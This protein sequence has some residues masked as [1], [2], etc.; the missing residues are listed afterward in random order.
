PALTAQRF[1][2]DPYGPPGSRM[3]RTGDLARMDTDGDLIYLGRTDHQVKIRGHRIE[4]AEIERALAEHPQVRQAVVLA[5]HRPTGGPERAGHPGQ[6]DDQRLVAYVVPEGREAG[7]EETATDEQVAEWRQVYDQAYAASAEVEW[8]EDFGIW[9]ST[10]TGEPI[11]LAEMRAWRDAAVDRVRGLAPRRVLELGVGTGLLLAHLAGEAEEYWGTDFSP[12]VID[13]LRRQVADAGLADRVRL[14]C[15]AADVTDGLPRGHFDAVVLNSVVQYFPHARY[16]AQVLDAAWEAL[17]PGGAIVV[18]DVRRAGT[19]R[20]LQGAV[21]RARQPQAPPSVLRAAVEQAVLLE[22]ELVVEPE[23]F[24]RWAAERGVGEVD[25]RLKSGRAHNELTR[26]RYEVVLRKAPPA[27]TWEAPVELVWGR[28]FAPA[29]DTAAGTTV[30]ARLAGPLR[31]HGDGPLRLSGIPN[32]RLA[33]ETA[34]AVELG[35]LAG[36]PAAAV[37]PEELREWAAGQGRTAVL[38]W[39]SYGVDRFDALL[40][41]AGSEPGRFVPW[42]PASVRTGGHVPERA[43][44]SAPARTGTRTGTPDGLSPLVN[45]PAAARRVAALPAALREHL[46]E[47]LPEYMLPSAVVPLGE[48]PLT[49]NGK[50]DRRA[51]PAPD[52]AATSGTGRA[53]ATPREK[54]LC[55]LFAEVLGVDRVGADDGFFALGGHSLLATRLVSRIRTVLGAE[56]PLRLVFQAPTPAALAA[57]LTAAA[58]GRP[59]LEPAERPETV[60]LSF[61]QRRMWFSYQLEG[62]SATYNWPLAL[63]LSGRLDAPA[64]RRALADVVARHESLRTVF[65][66]R[67]GQPCQRVLPPGAAPVPWEDRRLSEAELPEAMRRAARHTFDLSA[68]P[69]LRVWLFVT[70]P[71]EHVLLVLLHHIAGDGWSLEP[72]ARDLVTAYAARCA[73]GAPDWP[74]LPVQYVDYTL[75]QRRLL[76]DRDDPGS[77]YSRQLAYWREQLAGAPE[78]LRLPA[79]RPRP[80]VTSHAGDLAGFHLAAGLVGRLARLASAA[81]ATMAMVLQAGLAA[82][83]T[84]LGAGEDIPVGSP[85][86]G[87]TDEALHELVGFFVNTWVLRADTSGDPSFTE[88]LRRVRETSLAAYEHQDLPFDLLVE[89]LNPARSTA[90][91]SLFQVALALQ[92]NARPDFGLPGLRVRPESAPTGTA[93]FDL[94]LSLTERYD[95]EGRPA[96]IEGVAEYATDLFDRAGVEALLDRWRRLLE[97]VAADPG[98]PVGRAD[99]LTAEERDRLLRWAGAGREPV[100]AGVPELFARRVAETPG[101]PALVQG[102]RHWSYAGLDAWA[103]RFAHR[104][105]ALGA[106]PERRVALRMRRS[107]ALVAAVLGVLKAGAAYVPVDPDHPAERVAWLLEDSA[108]VAVVDDTWAE[109]DAAEL[110]G[111]PSTDPGVRVTGDHAA[112]LLYTSGSTGRPKGVI[113]THRNVTDLATD[114]CFGGDAHRGTLL[115]SPHTF[116]AS[117]YE[118]W[119]PLLAGGTVVVAPPG[120]L[121]PASLARAVTEDGVTA[122]W[123]TAGLFAVIADEHPEC[124]AGA[125][126]VWAGGDVLPPDAVRRVLRANPGLTVVNGYGPTETTTFATCHA[127]RTPGDLGPES[128]PIGT[129]LHGGRAFVLDRWLAPVPPGVAGELYVAGEGLARGYAGRPALTAERFVP[130]PYGPPGTRMYRTGDLVRWDTEG[131]LVFLGRADE[132][133]KL[134]GFRVEPG[135][136]EAVLREQP[137]VA[138]AVVVAREDRLRDRSLIA[139]VVPDGRAASAAEAAEQVGEWREIYDEMYGTGPGGDGGTGADQAGPSAGTGDGASGGPGGDP[140]ARTGSG[141]E[142]GPGAGAAGGPGGEP[143]SGTGAGRGSGTGGAGRL[144]EDFTGWNSSYTGRPIPVAEMRAWRDAA[145]ARVSEGRPRRVL[146][147]GVGSGLLLGPLAPATEAYWGTDFSAPVIDRLRRQVAADPELRDRVTLRCQAAEDTEGLPRAFFDTVVLN[148]VVQYFP[149]AD[150]LR[151]V[152]DRAM[153]LLVPGGRIVVGDVRNL[154]TLRA[155][156]T[157]VHR[158]QRPGDP[159]AAVHAAVE[160]AVLGEKEL[161]LDS[162]FFTAWAAERPE[163]GAVDIRLKCGAPHNELTRHR[164]E[165][166]LRKHPVEPVPLGRAPELAWDREFGGTGGRSGALLDAL[167]GAVAAAGGPL[168]VTGI[169]NARLTGEAAEARP[170]AVDPEELR[171]RCAERGLT[172]LCTWSPEAPDRFEAV[173]TATGRAAVPTTRPATGPEGVPAVGPATGPEGIPGAVP[174]TRPA[175]GPEGVPTAGPA[176]GPEGAGGVCWDGVYRADPARTR[177]SNAPAVSRSVARLPS[178]L[179]ER[180]AERLPEFMVPAAVV[181]LDRL[182]LTV[183][184]KLDRA[185]LP[186]PGRAGTAAHRPPRTEPERVLAAL[187][188]EVLGVDRVGLD[189]DF[190]DLG[191]HSL[192]VIRLIWRIRERLGAEI[193]IRV[194]FQSPTVAG[195]VPHLTPDEGREVMPSDPY[196]VLLPIRTEGE[197]LPLWW[198]HPGGGLC[199][200]YL[201]FAPHL[202][203]G[204]PVYGVQ[205]RGFHRG[206]ARPESIEEMVD[207]YL[208]QVRAV[209]PEGPYHLLGWS[210]GGTVAH[211]MAAE[212]QSRG[213]EVALLALLDCV[214]ASHFTRFDAPDEAQVREFLGHYMGHLDGMEEYPFLVETAASILVEHTVLMQKFGQPV[215]RGDAHFFNALLDPDGRGERRLETPFHAL[216]RPHVAGAVRTYDIACT[217]QEM[218]WPENAAEIGAI[219]NRLA[220]PGPGL[221]PGPHPGPGSGLASAYAHE[222]ENTPENKP[223]STRGHNGRNA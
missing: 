177:L 87:R 176:A 170:D 143:A 137:G 183:N 157:A 133:L 188:A 60:P 204:R 31:A 208:A 106:G 147:L 119:V 54:A 7:P 126:E 169:P 206:S 223:A 117:T 50:L 164:Y 71:E 221:G 175:T 88:L 125:R 159:A 210:F 70:G 34:L 179:R 97:Q 35:F 67:D 74:P 190:F 20:L 129:P 76:G 52:T 203:P 212:L 48:V 32:A 156:H 110:R 39:S 138:R 10:Y 103:N 14:R 153:E 91:H 15:Q 142:S 84:R 12:S 58:D 6:A 191:G 131:R 4:P 24:A 189:D 40:L 9:K 196:A 174:T 161:V 56:L 78:V 8:G 146:E 168:R 166:V 16:L 186:E 148:S 181:V 98:A 127:V 209:Q 80:P 51:L 45:D 134:R 222:P 38:S 112:Y 64:L 105:I 216:W 28:D 100:R 135:E 144:G 173:V 163:A 193:P 154:G 94:F 36:D 49:P 128:V 141:A 62:P 92:N 178:L 201:G 160:R 218:Y 130:C 151:R 207:D 83:L 124:L 68:E 11:P 73:G 107:P 215:F 136:I 72:F 1:T 185:A 23:W 43:G 22:K 113:T 123:L 5:R 162:G 211:A 198:V 115:H 214:P 85:I 90:H 172:A 121:T 217:H 109:E 184:G 18:G 25:V 158:A 27:T 57:R 145:V 102:G 171:A 26:H 89:A 152:L 213:E 13:R 44:G 2:P 53:P 77:A 46:R 69:P 33:G 17:A 86:A 30:P 120:R 194:V 82:L 111:V 140:G 63:R 81:G 99:L 65:E 197:R 66:E 195:L 205:A 79:A 19:L 118:L 150:Y 180:L 192:R 37:D 116:D 42:S 104:L 149:D 3:Y 199:W 55:E 75:W 132:Q 41:P 93:R 219:I 108:P 165:V 202:A 139:Y 182:P 59:A 220:G 155:F 95:A 47:R 101:A 61:A 200:P 114:P 167:S 96:G 122:L 21:Q 187:F 29:G